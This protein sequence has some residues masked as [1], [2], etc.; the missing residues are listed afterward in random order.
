MG[1]ERRTLTYCTL[2]SFAKVVKQPGKPQKRNWGIQKLELHLFPNVPSYLQPMAINAR[3]LNSDSWL[4]EEGPATATAL[5]S[6]RAFKTISE[7][8]LWESNLKTPWLSPV[9]SQ[10]TNL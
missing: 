2:P 9:Q 10:Q 1:L 6:K 5:L 3:H 4:A 7:R 8:I